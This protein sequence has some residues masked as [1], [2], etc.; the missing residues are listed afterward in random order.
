[1]TQDDLETLYESLAE[2]LDTLPA[3]ARELYL[4]KLA[5]ALAET[6]ENAPRALEIIAECRTGIAAG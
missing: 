5:L 6:L 1:M 3:E 4:A 2:S